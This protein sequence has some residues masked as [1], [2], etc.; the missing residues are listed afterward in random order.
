MQIQAV[1]IDFIPMFDLVIHVSETDFI[2][3]SVCVPEGEQQPRAPAALP[4]ARTRRRARQRR[5]R[6][7][8][9][10]SGGQGWALWLLGGV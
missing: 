8:K 10:D 4:G 9:E 6:R 1:G 2:F 7:G 5:G 3:Q